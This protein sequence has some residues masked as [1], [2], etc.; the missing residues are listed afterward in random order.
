MDYLNSNHPFFGVDNMKAVLALIEA[1]LLQ[2]TGTRTTF[3]ANDRFVEE[4]LQAARDYPNLLI[5]S[6]QQE[7]IAKLN[8]V[9]VG[10]AVRDL[11]DTAEAG[12]YEAGN[13]L[14]RI[15]RK[16]R[17]EDDG[18]QDPD[19]QGSSVILAGNIYKKHNDRFQQMVL[20]MQ[21]AYMSHPYNERFRRAQPKEHL[22]SQFR[23]LV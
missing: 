2:E 22:D 23:D 12:Q 10:R 21:D 14:H 16:T 11:T 19:R 7:G 17:R 8:T 13:Y 9:L 6:D 18:L 1:R 5:T 4:M 15:S 20:D 3:A